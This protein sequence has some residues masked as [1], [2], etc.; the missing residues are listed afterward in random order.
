MA[1]W[2]RTFSHGPRT[3]VFSDSG[4][5]PWPSVSCPAPHISVGVHGGT[6]FAATVSFQW[7]RLGVSELRRMSE[8]GS[9]SVL[10]SRGTGLGLPQGVQAGDFRLNLREDACSPVPKKHGGKARPRAPLAPSREGLCRPL[11]PGSRVKQ[12]GPLETT[13]CAKHGKY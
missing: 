4:C 1:G 13:P 6:K 7:E 5:C 3:H 8:S 12:A 11:N 9:S 10:F 2:F